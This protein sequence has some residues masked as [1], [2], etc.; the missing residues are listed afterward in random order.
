MAAEGPR[1]AFLKIYKKISKI[2]EI[3]FQNSGPSFLR[4]CIVKK[5]RLDS[6]KTDGGDRF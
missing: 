1:D 2:A 4:L 3:E 5:I 6:N